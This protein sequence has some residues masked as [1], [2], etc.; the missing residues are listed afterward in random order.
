MDRILAP[1]FVILPIALLLIIPEWDTPMKCKTLDYVQRARP[2]QVE[3]CVTA[4]TVI[5]NDTGT[6]YKHERDT[7]TKT[8]KQL[9]GQL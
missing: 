3:V 9:R 8:I 2:Q 7:L 6:L 1:L 4:D 5:F